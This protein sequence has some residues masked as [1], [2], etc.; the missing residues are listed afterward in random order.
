M[1]SVA[2]LITLLAIV[3][4]LAAL[5][6]RVRIAS[7]I[8][9]VLAG[10]AISLIPGLPSVVLRPDIV[11]LVFLPP[12]IYSAAWNTSWADFK[13]N[14]RPIMLLALG[15]VLFSTVGVAWVVHTFVPG[16]SWPLAFVMGATVSTTDP[17]AGTS[18]IKQMGLPRRVVIILEAESLVNDATGLIVYRYA[19]AAV[20]TGQFVLIEAGE[21]FFVVVLGGILI[22]L[23]LA[24][25]VKSIHQLTDDTPVVET[26]LTFLTPFAGYLIAEEWHVSG[27]L[28][29]LSAGLFLTLRSSEFLSRQAHLQTINVW[30]VVTF[31]LNSIVFV[32]MGLQLR[33]ILLTTSGYS[34][35]KLLLYGALVSLA[36][37]LSRFIWVFLASYL[38]RLV[39]NRTAKSGLLFNRKLNTVIGWTGMRG[40]LSLATALA[41]P[42]TLRNG[43]PF[44]Q[45]DLIIFFT[46]CVIFSTLVLQG[47]AL[48]YL[49]RW[50]NITPDQRAKQEEINLRIQLA[51]MAIE[52][53]EANYSLSEEVSDEAL[54]LLK[55]KYE[56]RIDRL[57]LHQ[58]GR[59]ANANASEVRETMRI[60]LEIIR[61]ERELATRLR[62]EG[63]KDDE[64]LRTILYELDLEESRLLLETMR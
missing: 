39:V 21:Q 18:I 10:I 11:I 3:T 44:P 53:L 23:A 19:V 22:G 50:L 29:V 28:A 2:L 14:F 59:R 61:V 43:S 41:L 25:V 45:R 16:F 30:N 24:W 64:V 55:H 40:V 34:P 15:L 20:T 60:Q 5:A 32:L 48:P 47:L 8:V 35:S 51:S 33:R 17:I 49:I 52:H 26:T 56:T 54:A 27:V 7:P 38:P 63:Q 1:S 31:L 58:N 4:A 62:R 9:L 13:A 12:L 46:Y 57:R 6:E 37:I 36:V 42:L